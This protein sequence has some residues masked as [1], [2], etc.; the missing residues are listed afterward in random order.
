MICQNCQQKQATINLNLQFNNEKQQFRL[1]HTCYQTMQSKNKI[2]SGFGGGFQVPFDD[3]FKQMANQHMLG[4]HPGELQTEQAGGNGSGFLDQFGRNLSHAAKA[5]LID[6]VIG[7]DEEVKR[8]TEILNRRNKNN[9]V[10]IGEP[11]VGK[12]AIAEGLALKITLGDVPS[13]LANKEVYLLDVA[14]LVANT[15][16]RGQFE[17]RMKQL[18]AEL[19]QRK[20]II[21]FIDEIHLLVGAGSA[22][23][24][25]DAG[26]ILKP[27]LARGELQL[28][29][30]TTLKEYRAIEK[31]AALERRFQPVTVHEPSV[32]DAIT[33]LKGIQSKYEDYHR[34]HYTSEAIEACVRLSHRYIQ[35]R[36]LPDKAIDLLDEA[37]SKINLKVGATSHDE[38]EKRLS[39]LAAEKEKALK[40]ENYEA[41]AKLRD[42]EALLEKCLQNK[43][44]DKAIVDVETIQSIIEKKTGIPV[45]KLQ[46]NESTKMKNLAKNLVGKVI[47]Q[48]EA[49]EKVAKAVRR[50]RAGLKAKHR[51]IGS[52]LFVGPTGVG[53]TELTKR[54][55]EELFGSND[56][57]V[58]LDMSE[59]MEK[60]SVSKLIGSPPGYVGHEEA[61]QL[62]E[63]VRRNPYSIILLDEIEK[64]HPDVQ[65]MFLQILEDGRLTDSQGRTVSFQDTVIIMTSNAGVGSKNITVGF[66]AE[67]QAKQPSVL[68]SLSVYFKPEFLNR[69]D[70]IIEFNQL[71]KDSLLKIV[72]LMLNELQTKLADQNITITVSQE[73]KEKLAELGYNPAFG[74]R[75]LRRVIEEQ[76][77]DRLTDLILDHG[78]VKH[79]E[80]VVK[81]NQIVVK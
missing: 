63:M 34:V 5:G 43:E 33:I 44:E 35:D 20:N 2:P 51:P 38:I 70:A 79:V 40:E 66:G 12:T 16:I 57:M 52:F 59:Y 76:L 56:A 75:P 29:G 71:E 58:R 47:G 53:K 25:M 28:I 72:D 69:F 21:L 81:E 55:A 54:L 27:A 60:H 1:C 18:I 26:N 74:A 73:A 50:S 13:K 64:A 62:T 61:G 7:R 3:L 11:G 9:P 41:A 48:N 4:K 42:E 46:E 8:I 24:S 67:E 23:G 10:L 80:V 14:S 68:D 15:G 30:A 37:G 78:D 17:E 22:E 36:F 19:Q 6:P 32:E 31:D 39:D 49:V 77:E 45:G 65:H